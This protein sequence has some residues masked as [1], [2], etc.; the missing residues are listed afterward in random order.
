MK[1]KWSKVR[2]DSEVAEWWSYWITRIGVVCIIV[3]LLMI[4]I[5]IR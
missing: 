5:L 1:P 2:D 3:L 4:P